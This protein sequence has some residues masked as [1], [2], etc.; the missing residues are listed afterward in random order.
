MYCADLRASRDS[1]NCERGT[2]G[3]SKP[4]RLLDLT[5]IPKGKPKL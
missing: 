1:L 5:L 4:A 2:G 3:P